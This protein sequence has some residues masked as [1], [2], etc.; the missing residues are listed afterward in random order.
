MTVFFSMKVGLP[1]HGFW[2][3]QP[4]STHRCPFPIDWLINRGVVYPQLQQVNDD[5]WYTKPTPLFL[6][7][8]Q[9]WFN[10]HYCRWTQINSLFLLLT[11]SRQPRPLKKT[12]PFRSKSEG[13]MGPKRGGWVSHCIGRV[14][15]LV[16]Q[17]FT[18]VLSMFY[19]WT[20]PINF[21]TMV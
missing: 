5:R 20:L 12:A 17:C 4:H 10:H 6:P 11:P 15:W 8:G 19:P 3:F 2:K 13:S 14:H 16:Y 18:H 21:A 7:K 9:Y 1:K